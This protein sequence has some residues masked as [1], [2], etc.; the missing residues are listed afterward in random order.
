MSSRSRISEG[1]KGA[2]PSTTVPLTLQ[3]LKLSMRVVRGLPSQ[4]AGRKL[5]ESMKRVVVY[6]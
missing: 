1:S 4:T 2:I 3:V 5:S 6:F